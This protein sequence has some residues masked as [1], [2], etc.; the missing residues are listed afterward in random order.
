MAR[1]WISALNETDE[2]LRLSCGVGGR[3]SLISSSGVDASSDE[4]VSLRADLRGVRRRWTSVS[5]LSG[6]GGSSGVGGG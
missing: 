2:R 5:G 6:V 1:S 3:G 4:G